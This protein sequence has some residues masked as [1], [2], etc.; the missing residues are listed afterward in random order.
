[1]TS[2]LSR[3]FRV[4]DRGKI[5]GG[6]LEVGH[7]A[8]VDVL[9]AAGGAV[10][11]PRSIRIGSLELT[12]GIEEI[13]PPGLGLHLVDQRH[14]GLRVPMRGGHRMISPR[15]GVETTVWVKVLKPE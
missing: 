14:S 1:M 15:S 6:E 8:E 5:G 3:P 11:D 7:L 9:L 13:E 2:I 10:T 4:V 12:Q